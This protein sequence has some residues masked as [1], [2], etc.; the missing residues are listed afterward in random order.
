MENE[1]LFIVILT[2]K[3]LCVNYAI[4]FFIVIRTEKSHKNSY[5]RVT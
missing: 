3:I 2:Y 1:I 4:T 5:S